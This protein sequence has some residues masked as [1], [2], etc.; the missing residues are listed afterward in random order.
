LDRAEHIKWWDALDVLTGGDNRKGLLMARDCQN[1]DAQWLASLFPA[2]DVAKER[3][4]EVLRGQGDDARASFLLWRL[5]LG[6]GAWKADLKRPVEMGYAPA[7]VF[8]VRA[9]VRSRSAAVGGAI[10]RAGRPL[11]VLPACELPV[12]RTRL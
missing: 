12:S 7:Q 4:V 3:L 1:P 6:N 5:P 9:L 2:A 10:G 11:R 8:L